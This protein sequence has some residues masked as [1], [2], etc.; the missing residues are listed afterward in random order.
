M[1]MGNCGSRGGLRLMVPVWPTAIPLEAGNYGS[2]GGLRVTIPVKTPSVPSSEKSQPG[3]PLNN[4]TEPPSDRSE[5]Q[6]W[7]N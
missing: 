2:R 6:L 7:K 3:A 1:I 5:A 4:N